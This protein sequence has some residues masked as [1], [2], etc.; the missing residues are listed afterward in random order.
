MF[1]DMSSNTN[2]ALPA[3][4]AA[5]IIPSYCHHE[6]YHY[7]ILC[8]IILMS[9]SWIFILPLSIML[10]LA[11]SPFRLPVQFGFLVLNALA[12]FF[13]IL[14]NANTPN[15]YEGNAH[16]GFGWVVT[17]I[18]GVQ[19]LLAL[20]NAYAQSGKSLSLAEGRDGGKEEYSPLNAE[21]LYKK[22]SYSYSDSGQGASIGR[23]GTGSATSLP[24]PP[25]APTADHRDFNDVLLAPAPQSFGSRYA[26]GSYLA[27]IDSM[28]NT[29]SSLTLR[30][31]GFAENFINRT[32]LLLGYAAI[33]TGIATYGGLFRGIEV[34]SGMAHW[35]KGSVFFW[36]GIL[37]LGRWAGC[38]ADRGWAWN[39]LPENLKN[40]KYSA[41][42]VEATLMFI[43]GST[44]VFLAHLAAWGKEWSATDLEHLAIAVL[45]FGGGLVCPSLP[46]IFKIELLTRNSAECS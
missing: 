20:I 26:F 36:Y 23:S 5:E 43:Y 8:H 9:I 6:D 42:F 25:T 33:L 40:K 30:I 12:V 1:M 31:L 10:T 24:Q 11:Q 46:L 29:L 38:F 17:W 34:H 15:L 45:F 16:H 39:A 32:I 21:E 14:Y 18:V 13:S 35:I 19:M 3:N 28:L 7:L 2:L 44:N 37:T 4:S 27:R 41:E 22:E